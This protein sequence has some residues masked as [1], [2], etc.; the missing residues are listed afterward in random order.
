MTIS[1]LARRAQVGT[2]TIRFYEREGLLAQP[3]KPAHGYRQYEA[4]HLEQLRFI[5]QCRGFGFTLAEAK[6]LLQL[7]ERNEE[8]GTE[9]R[10]GTCH[11]A[12]ELAQRKVVELR[13]RIAE[14]EALAQRLEKLLAQP[15]RAESG[16]CGVMAELGSVH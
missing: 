6:Q 1:E 10:Q 7:W 13:Q 5:R 9:A 16:E 3:R 8:A 2:E 11:E 14:S 12:C 4:R 15:S